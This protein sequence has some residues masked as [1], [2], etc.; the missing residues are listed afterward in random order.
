MLPSYKEILAEEEGGVYDELPVCAPMGEGFASK[1]G[2]TMRL[3][4]GMGS[5]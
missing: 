5:R 3:Q 2:I 4:I 1:G